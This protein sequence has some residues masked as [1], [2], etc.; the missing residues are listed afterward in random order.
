MGN[1]PRQLGGLTLRSAPLE[2]SGIG[3]ASISGMPADYAMYIWADTFKSDLL[4][5][6][7]EIYD[8]P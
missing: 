3:N 2:F 4:A 5:A 8:R 7:F 6:A 1:P